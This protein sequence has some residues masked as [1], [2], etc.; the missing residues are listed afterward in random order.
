MLRTEALLPAMSVLQEVAE[1][2]L[3]ALAFL[4]NE[5]ASARR[6]PQRQR[7][8]KDGKREGEGREGWK[9]GEKEEGR[10]GRNEERR[11]TS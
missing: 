6:E 3:L 2:G 7:M 5:R 8:Y 11:K 1:P 10:G 9:R 4:V